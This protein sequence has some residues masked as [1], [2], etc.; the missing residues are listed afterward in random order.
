MRKIL[1]PSH[2]R[3]G[4]IGIKK[5][6][7]IFPAGEKVVVVCDGERYGVSIPK[8]ANYM[9]G[10]GECHRRHKA[11]TGTKIDI[12]QDKV[13][14]N[15]F[16]LKYLDWKE[17]DETDPIRQAKFLLETYPWLFCRN[18]TNVRCEIIDPI[19][20]YCGWE[21]P[22]LRREVYMGRG[23]G[24]SDYILYQ[25]DFPKVIVEAKS[26]DDEL[27]YDKIKEQLLKYWEGSYRIPDP[28]EVCAIATNGQE[29]QLWRYV[30]ND[31]E[32][33]SNADIV[34]SDGGFMLFVKYLKSI[35]NND[36][37]VNKILERL[38]KKGTSVKYSSDRHSDFIISGI[39]GKDITE[40]FQ[41][42]V[43]KYKEYREG[44]VLEMAR[45]GCFDK[46]IIATSREDAIEQFGKRPKKLIDGLYVTSDYDTYTKR[47]LVEQI[48]YKLG[49]EET[50]RV[51]LVKKQ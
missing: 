27:A 19:L 18:E 46:S 6:D 31:A 9:S 43:V 37:S 22:S 14:R 39:D 8:A 29:W 40:R 7:G 15:V 38:R 45:M 32:L 20:K 49:L 35:R 28:T 23:K 24:Q 48:I 33:V 47:M 36:S 51:E 44:G 12:V 5:D 34:N 13:N 41:K 1:Q 4:L 3:Y 10:L 42:F 50:H 21:F 17:T 16:I 2:I 25:G 11:I 30:G 26:H